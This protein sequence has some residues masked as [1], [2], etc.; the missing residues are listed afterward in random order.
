MIFNIALKNFLR[1]GIRSFL[2]TLVISLVI[3]AVIFNLSLYN[4]FQSQATR[5]MVDTDVGGGHYVVPGF[6]L[7]SPTEWEDHTLPVPARLKNLPHSEKAEILVLQG[8]IYPN[9]RLFP[10]QLRGVNID[11]NLLKLSLDGLKPVDPIAGQTIPVVLGRKIAEKAHLKKGNSVIMK[12]R[13]RFGAVDAR[14]IKVKD[15]VDFTNPRINEG[16]VWLRLDH[17]RQITQR[18]EEVSWVVVRTFMGTVEGLEYHSVKKL[19]SDLLN[20]IKNDRRYAKIMWVILLFMAG[21]SIF[22]T[23]ILNLFKRQKEVGTYLALGMTARQIMWLF[24]LE[25][26]LA[27]FGAVVLAA[28]LGIPF[29]MWF[30]S[31]G[32]DVSHLSEST[33]PIQENIILKFLP[34]EVVLTAIVIVVIMI[35]LA[36][37]PVKKISRMSPTLALRGRALQ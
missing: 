28:L 8:Q 16:I 3:V 36:W 1:Q 33:I 29:F 6:D 12:W 35:F 37:F 27:A 32:L 17:L 25:G 14:Q 31:V 21:I 13:D 30:Q 10:V 7:L 15:V 19:M 9:R 26:S 2:N 4:G 23:Q 20:L 22:N 5:N 34:H 24:T 11:Q 18:P